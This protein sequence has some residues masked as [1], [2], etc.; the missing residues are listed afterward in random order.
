MDLR[1]K[2]NE[3]EYN[4][5]KYRPT[6][7]EELFSDIINYSRI[8][9]GYEALEIGIGTG[10]A[11]LPILQS[12]CRVTAIE[13]GNNLTRYVKNKFKNYM[14]FNV[15]NADFIEYTIKTEAFNLVY[16][17]TAFHWIP[18]EQGYVKVRNILKDDGTIA[19]FWNH[20]FPNRQDD[21]SNIVNRK[22]YNKYRPSDKEVREFNESDCQ[23]RINELERFGFK[24]I[25]Y[26]LYHRKRTLTSNGYIH[27]LNTYSDHRVLP[28]EVKNNFEMDMKNA[29]D[30]IGGKINIYDTIDLYLAKKK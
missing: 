28:V 29:I 12:G 27:L 20:P 1:L 5:D 19:L 11:T 4:Y 3:D 30:E 15:I 24:D 7:P 8:S 26:R 23:R 25:I 22:I 2:F 13:L 21:I 18:L 16:C 6:Y 14:N 9:S 10:Q 17:A